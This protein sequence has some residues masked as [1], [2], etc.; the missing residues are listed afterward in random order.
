MKIN[1]IIDCG[2]LNVSRMFCTIDMRGVVQNPHSN[3]SSRQ[4]TF[5]IRCLLY[6]LNKRVCISATCIFSVYFSSFFRS[7]LSLVHETGTCA[8][9]PYVLLELPLVF[10]RG[11]KKIMCR[12]DLG[13]LIIKIHFSHSNFINETIFE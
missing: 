11:Q 13:G 12:Y 9:S 7:F 6:L 1:A 8:L 5:F 2:L 3:I 4:C 10:E